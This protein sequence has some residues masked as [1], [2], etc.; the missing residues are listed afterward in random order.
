[1]TLT[2]P[3]PI[4]LAD[5][6]PAPPA[7]AAEGT[8]TGSA[9]NGTRRKAPHRSRPAAIALYILLGFVFAV[10]AIPIYWLFRALHASNP[11]FTVA[12][13]QLENAQTSHPRS[14]SSPASR[15]WARPSP[16]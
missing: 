16:P 9:R 14:G 1:M 6:A 10:F 4:A 8:R 2:S 13:E 3:R 11:S 12:I 5:P 15:P 7:E